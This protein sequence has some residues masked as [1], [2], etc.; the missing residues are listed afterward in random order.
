MKKKESIRTLLGISQED[1]AILIKVSRAQWSMYESGKR[2]LPAE[3]TIK[4]AEMFEHVQLAKAKASK[5]PSE[6]SKET[7]QNLQALLK[8]NEYQ[9]SLTERKVKTLEKKQAATLA[10]LH[11]V[12]YFESNARKQETHTEDCIKN[13]QIKTKKDLERHGLHSL[14]TQQIKQQVLEYERSLLKEALENTST[15]S[16]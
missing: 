15:S 12:N 13:I 16:A 9:Q 4:L 1:I 6:L 10:A 8:E 2:N 3:A 5:H 14:I 7:G 11:L